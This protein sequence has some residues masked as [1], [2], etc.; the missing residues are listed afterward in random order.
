MAFQTY[1][2]IT[3]TRQGLISAGCSTEASIGTRYR[4]AHCDEIMVLS[5]SH[6]LANLDNTQV[7]SHEPVILTKLI[8]KAT[9]LLAQALTERELVE[10]KFSFYRINASGHHEKY[11]SIKLSGGM[12]IKLHLDVPH[13]V[14]LND[15]DAQEHVAIRYRDIS[16]NHHAAG[17]SG[18]AA[19]GHLAW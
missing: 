17:T 9:P 14:L 13:S 18:H 11:L 5:F 6:Q 4:S 3:G 15:Q 1:L 7:V 8:D 12:I 16:W 10:C 2:S 19:W